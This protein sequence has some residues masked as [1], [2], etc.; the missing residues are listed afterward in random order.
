METPLWK[1]FI[2]KFTAKLEELDA[3]E[4]DDDLF[5][6]DDYQR[7]FCGDDRQNCKYLQSIQ[8]F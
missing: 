1:H 4:A 6:E 2:G 3:E 8:K 7:K 5:E